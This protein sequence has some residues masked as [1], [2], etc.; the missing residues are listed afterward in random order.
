MV[1]Q[2]EELE[3]KKGWVVPA[4][5][6]EALRGEDAALFKEVFVAMH[7]YNMAGS[8]DTSSMTPAARVLFNVFKETIDA[9][10]RRYEAIKKRNQETAQKRHRRNKGGL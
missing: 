9:N 5:S 4:A 3:K 7:D 1:E 6:V 2:T 8:L 10:M